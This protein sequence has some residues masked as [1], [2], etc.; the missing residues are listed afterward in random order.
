MSFP[1]F[2]PPPQPQ[3]AGGGRGGKGNDPLQQLRTMLQ[4]QAT[5]GQQQRAEQT[6]QRQN[7]TT[8]ITG[9]QA[10]NS[11]LAIAGALGVPEDSPQFNAMADAGAESRWQQNVENLAALNA[12]PGIS[13]ADKD[14]ANAEAL[15]TPGDPFALDRMSERRQQLGLRTSVKQSDRRESQRLIDRE[16][17]QT[18]QASIDNFVITS[19]SIAA[20]QSLGVLAARNE[21]VQ[22]EAERL[23]GGN[24]EQL[25]V[26]FSRIEL[27]RQRQLGARSREARG[28][29]AE[30]DMQRRIR[31]TAEI[32]GWTIPEATA[33]V[34]GDAIR[35]PATNN[36]M[37]VA[38]G[39]AGKEMERRTALFMQD[40]QVPL[41]K[42]TLEDIRA[43]A[44]QEFV[45]V[46]PFFGTEV[47]Q[48]AL[49]FIGR[50]DPLVARYDTVQRSLVI[51]QLKEEQN[52]RISDADYR[53]KM[54]TWPVLTEL[55]GPAADARIGVYE[56]ILALRKQVDYN[57]K[58]AA[59]MQRLR[60][61]PQSKEDVAFRSVYEAYSRDEATLKEFTLAH[62]KWKKARGA[63]FNP[64]SERKAEADATGAPGGSSV[65]D[66]FIRDSGILE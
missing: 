39:T 63:T 24:P 30:S 54:A 32:N 29:Q 13:Q 9:V 15:V 17:E 35:D 58:A 10:G 14:R 21:E 57:P 34:N 1:V 60:S 6:A 53:I 48:D 28:P 36:I 66:D 49:R 59:T 62:I 45:A 27:E 18:R 65:A 41:L 20:D 12:N 61:I 2:Q 38:S 4:L 11:P 19:G 47:V 37:G 56:E 22:R 5:V 7:L 40:Q 23:S 31:A 52:G 46:G 51:N 8:G 33:M 42:S 43:K 50:Q 55:L 44:A 25:T 3:G 16:A 26:I 64:L